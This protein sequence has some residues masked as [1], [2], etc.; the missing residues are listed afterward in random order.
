MNSIRVAGGT[1]PAPL[2]CPAPLPQSPVMH[3]SVQDVLVQIL[4]DHGAGML[5]VF[6]ACEGSSNP[7]VDGCDP[8]PIVVGQLFVIVNVAD[9]P[10]VVRV[11]FRSAISVLE[12]Y[13]VQTYK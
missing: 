5:M 8:E 7:V 13:L 2:H 12:D 11:Q 3:L 9:S 1:P 6:V 10:P 4:L